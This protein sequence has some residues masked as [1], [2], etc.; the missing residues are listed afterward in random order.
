MPPRLSEIYQPGALVEI[1]FEL[2]G[3]QRWLAGRVVM[4][5]HPGL[6]V[7]TS[8]GRAW[9]VTN[10]RRIR[11]STRS[12]TAPNDDEIERGPARPETEP[13]TER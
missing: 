13:S 3:E 4:H 10:A 5:Q 8:D 2:A 7:R 1:L 6:W 9:F 11:G 12:E